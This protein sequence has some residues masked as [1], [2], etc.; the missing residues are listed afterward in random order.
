MSYGVG[1]DLGPWTEYTGRDEH[2]IRAVGPDECPNGHPLKNP[3]VQIRSNV[4]TLSYHCRRC[5]VITHRKRDGSEWFEQDVP[6]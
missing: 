1:M 3:N 2:E 6:F 4:D 5:G